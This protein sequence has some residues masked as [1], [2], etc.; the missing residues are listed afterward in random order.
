MVGREAAALV[1]EDGAGDLVGGQV[2]WRLPAPPSLQP[3]VVL[4]VKLTADPRRMWLRKK[5]RRR[6]M[7]L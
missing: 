1:G 3:E 5:R 2:A 4:E 7:E 6:R